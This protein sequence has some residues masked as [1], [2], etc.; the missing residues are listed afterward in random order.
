M[1][2]NKDNKGNDELRELTGSY[3]KSNDFQK[4][5]SDILWATEDLIKIIGL[6][7]YAR[8][9]NEYKDREEPSELVEY[10]QYPIAIKA[11]MEMYRK[12][13][14]SHGDD[15]RKIQIDS[16]HEKLPWEW[17][18]K[19]DDAIQLDNYYK[20]VDRLLAF[21]DR[22]E[23]PEWTNS[24]NKKTADSLF[25]RNA[26]IFDRYFPIEQSGRMYMILLP[27]IREAERLYIKP[28]LGAD[29]KKL[30]SKTDLS[31]HEN[32]LLEYV[33]P[34][35]PLFA[36]SIAIRRL[37]IGIIPAGIIR[38][39]IS[40]SETMNAAQPAT[41]EEIRALS[42]WLMD[43]ALA[44]LNDMKTFRNGRTNYDLLPHNCRKNKYMMV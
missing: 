29:Y 38:N 16:V 28:A 5:K 40:S 24:E 13:D 35:V 17:Q 39:Y 10:V 1:I 36:M 4:I 25:V 7:V 37:P 8:A 2:F 22:E 6:Q 9:E 14:V 34:P 23:I 11:T 32:E 41:V 20:A 33:Y 21:L 26:E 31:E 27:F 18:L 3:Y 30:L 15:G 42:S 19:R 43:D 44:L 12:N